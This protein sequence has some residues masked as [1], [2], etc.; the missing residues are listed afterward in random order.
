MD[1]MTEGFQEQKKMIQDAFAQQ[2]VFIQSEFKKQTAFIKDQFEMAII[3]IKQVPK[4]IKSFLTEE[5]VLKV[6]KQSVAV[7]DYLTEKQAQPDFAKV[8]LV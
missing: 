5:K 1:A 8:Y 7:L 2:K 4:E 6:K 3:A